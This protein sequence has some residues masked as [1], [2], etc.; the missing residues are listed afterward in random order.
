MPALDA[1]IVLILC[2][3]ELPVL[4]ALLWVLRKL[5]RTQV[6]NDQVLFVMRRNK[7]VSYMPGASYWRRPKDRVVRTLLISV[8][9]Y[10]AVVPHIVVGSGLSVDVTLRF[11]ASLAVDHEEHRERLLDDTNRHETVVSVLRPHLQR[12][13]E[14]TLRSPT[15]PMPS[16]LGMGAFLHPLF[17]ETLPGILKS[18]HFHARQDL[19][20]YGILLGD[21]TLK[22][23]SLTLAS[24]IVKAYHDLERGRYEEVERF[25]FVKRIEDTSPGVSEQALVQ[26]YHAVHGA[27]GP[28]HTVL[29]TGVIPA[30]ML[31]AD[32]NA[33][34]ALFREPDS[35]QASLSSLA[36]KQDYPLTA[37]AMATLKELSQ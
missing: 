37:E 1:R 23:E 15:A 9:D 28:L 33:G 6:P 35:A 24:E 27:S 12:L 7:E 19:K 17:G 3:V 34:V 5:L 25:R 13:V 18:L 22:L 21:Q 29:S 10:R 2:L 11:S 14:K 4:L 26:L 20:R 32:R 30:D 36:P 31:V 8:Q 16:G